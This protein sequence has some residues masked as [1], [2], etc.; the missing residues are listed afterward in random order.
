[1]EAWWAHTVVLAAPIIYALASVPAGGLRGTDVLIWRGD[2]EGSGKL[3][4]SGTQTC[5]GPTQSS[6]GVWLI[7][8]FH[9]A[10]GENNNTEFGVRR[11]AALALLVRLKVPLGT[12]HL[13]C[14][15]QFPHL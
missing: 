1:M 14:S 9:H 5:P 3:L 10:V 12:L 4:T 7:L 11:H 8:Q 6:V 15:S 2:Q 13:A